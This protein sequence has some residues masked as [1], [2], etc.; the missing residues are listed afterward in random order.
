M[1]T[2]IRRH[3][4]ISS[5]IIYCGFAIGLLNTYFFTKEGIFTKG[6]YGLAVGIFVPVAV[7]LASLSTLATP[8]YIYKFYP[9]YSKNVS[10]KKNDMITWALLVGVAG[11]GVVSFFGWLFQDL[12][13]RKYSG[14]SQLFVHYYY[15]VYVLAFGLTVYNVLEAYA[16]SWHKSVFTNFLKEFQWR[17]FT[18]V[19]IVLFIFKIIP[20]FDLFIKLYS[21]TFLGIAAI[22]FIYLITTGK[23]HFTFIPSKV[24][25]RFFN[26]ITRYCS[27]IYSATIVFTLSAVFDSL[28]I[29][30][31][32]DNGLEKA[33]IFILAQNLSSIIQAPQRG[34]TAAA[35]PHITQ[36]WKD[37]NI[38]LIQRI[39]QRSSINLLIFSLLLFVLITINYKQAIFVF[40]LKK[41]FALG[42]GAFIF[43]GLTRVIDLGTGV[44]AQI[45]GTSN[46]WKFELTSGIIL[47]ILTLPLTY[48]LTKQ[49]GIIGPPIAAFIANILYN[50]IRIGFL[51]KKFKLFPFTVTS[52]YTLLLAVIVFLVSW[53]LFDKM[54][55]IS[56]I[57][58]RSIFVIGLFS[59]GVVLLKLTPDLRPV[60][61]TIKKKLKFLK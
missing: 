1:S 12:V 10:P 51:W 14:N 43:M 18:T 15:W 20:D 33:G 56:G 16:W 42:F 47:L 41:E 38:E 46:Y 21:F 13:V 4:I 48:I 45:I 7:L 54:Q 34:V 61:Q 32:L 31:V 3:S 8:S 60:L 22:L 55:G 37:K 50:A 40:G 5:V 52:V 11:F 26:I 39:Y 19:L 25:R 29:A 35:I 58:I 6:E 49:M 30:S 2:N 36:A 53:I 17:F 28:V 23:I 9:Y 57:F 59:A 27:F 44:N 24:S